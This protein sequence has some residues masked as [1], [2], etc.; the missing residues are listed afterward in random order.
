M[1]KR[2]LSYAK[3][4]KSQQFENITQNNFEYV[5]IC[6]IKQCFKNINER[7][8]FR[9]KRSF[10]TIKCRIIKH[11]YYMLFLLLIFV[12]IVRILN[13]IF[14]DFYFIKRIPCVD[15]V[16]EYKRHKYRNNTHCSECE[17]T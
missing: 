4:I 1:L 6:K 12:L 15:N 14:R 8:R 16:C 2:S 10:A 3:I 9:P 11:V 17:F 5:H 7:F 13:F